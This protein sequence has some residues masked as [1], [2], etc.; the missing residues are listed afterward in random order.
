MEWLLL[1][2]LHETQ[3]REVKFGDSDVFCSVAGFP[4]QL[5]K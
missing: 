4:L 2:V 5:C 3:F 1:V